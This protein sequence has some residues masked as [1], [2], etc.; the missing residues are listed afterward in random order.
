[1]LATVSL[2]YL[3]LTQAPPFYYC[4]VGFSLFFWEQILEDRHLLLSYF[5][6]GL[7]AAGFS[8]FFARVL[9]LAVGLELLVWILLACSVFDLFLTPL[10]CFRWQATFG[11]KSCL[12]FSCLWHV[13]HLPSPVTF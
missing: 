10:C 2:G 7:K 5:S 3:L 12:L 13:G 1:L 9:S 6:F 8:T 11:G 4:Y